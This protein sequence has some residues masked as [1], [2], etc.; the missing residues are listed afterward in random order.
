VGISKSR[1]GHACVIDSHDA[2]IGS[3]REVE[4]HGRRYLRDQADV[5]YRGTLAMAEPAACGMF[6]EQRLN[7]LQAS[8]KPMLDP[9]EPLVIADLQ[10]VREIMP[11]AWH[12]QR[13]RVGHVDQCKPTQYVTLRGRT[14]RPQHA[15]DCL[16]AQ[17]FVMGGN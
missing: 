13:V 17:V 11:D 3:K 1:D 15:Q 9:G 5:R 8:A 4:G 12:D 6:G 14:M 10:D 2:R 16:A 7:C